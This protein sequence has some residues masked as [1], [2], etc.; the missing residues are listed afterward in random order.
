MNIKTLLILSVLCS[1]TTA[2]A[3]RMIEGTIYDQNQQPLIGAK[4]AVK[5]DRALKAVTDEQGKYK[6]T[7][8]QNQNITL[9]VSYL[10]YQSEQVDLSASENNRLF[11]LKEDNTDLNEVVVTGTRTPRVLKDAPILTRVISS[12]DIA[13]SD[14]TNIGDLLQSELPGIEFSFAMDQQ[15][16]LNMQGFGGNAVLFLVDGERISGETLDNIDYSRLSLDNVERV[17]IVKGAASSLYGSNAVGGVVNLISKTAKKPWSLNL[18]AKAGAHEEQRYGGA[19]GNLTKHTNNMFNV[20]YNKIGSYLMKGETPE[21]N[22]TCYGNEV[23][24]FKDRFIYQPIEDLKLTAKAGY[25]FRERDVSAMQK[26]RYRGFNGGLK[27]NY[28]FN[29]A[30]NLELSYTFDQYDKSDYSPKTDLDVRDYSNVQHITRG[31]YNHTFADKHFLTLGADYMRDY[32]MSYQ[33][34]DGAHKQHT[35]DV[36]AQF[37]W[38]PTKNFNVI[39]GIRYDYFSAADM[40]HVSPK[41][42]MMYKFNHGSLRASY[43]SG[44]RAPT[45]KEMYMDFFMGNIFM[46]YGNADLK[47]ESSHNLLLTGEYNL[48]RYNFTLSGFYNLVDNRITTAW[49]Q[50]LDGMKYTNMAQLRIGGIDANASVKY[51][52]GFGARISYVYTHEHIKKGEPLTSS[53][54]PHTATARFEYDKRWK[55]YGFNLSLTGRVLSEVTVDEYTKANSY[56]ETER[57]TYPGYTL[58]KLHLNQ[59]IWRGMN[60]SFIVDNLFNYKP[61]NYEYNSPTST[62]TTVS[63][64]LCINVDQLFK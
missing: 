17:E 52:C 51:P 25:F 29:K 24:N 15:K 5:G 48:G 41:L 8:P 39:A 59:H 7:V 35:T 12:E 4:V 13:K 20:E 63:A 30:S 50:A 34:T 22:V 64:G 19:L 46:I 55:N 14:A 33:F 58:W 3:Q 47:P 10:G 42:G 32:L 28:D 27:G 44:F 57:K 40:Q 56:E 61:K 60:I 26:D 38:N 6:L 9:Q 2:G 49:N 18:N 11:Y 45:L 54:R 31:L 21:N 1:T 37:D 43:A 36:F 16:S 53:T 62:G 23:W